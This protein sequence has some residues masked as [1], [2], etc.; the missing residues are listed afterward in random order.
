M[1]HPVST[2]GRVE[3]KRGTVSSRVVG[4]AVDPQ[5]PEHADPSASEDSYGVGVIAASGARGV[6]TVG[7]PGAGTAGVVGEAGDGATQPMIA[8]PAEGDAA[9][10]ARLIG[11]GTCTGLCG[12][13]IIGGVA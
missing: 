11:Y 13:L 12:E 4:G 1:R 5:S 10:L 2:L 8:G 9:V 6:V 7:G 3:G